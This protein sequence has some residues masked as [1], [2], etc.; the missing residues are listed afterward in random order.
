MEEE[1]ENLPHWL[2]LENTQ[3]AGVSNQEHFNNSA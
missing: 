3:H 1:R 2:R